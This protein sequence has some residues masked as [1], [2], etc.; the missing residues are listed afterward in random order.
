MCQ[1]GWIYDHFPRTFISRQITMNY[2]HEWPTC[3]KWKSLRATGTIQDKRDKLDKLPADMVIWKP[4]DD[5]RDSRPFDDVALFRGWL[6]HQ[7]DI[8]PLHP[9]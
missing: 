8:M 4:Y 6:H 1:Q 2:T 3:M 9:R 5:H 7:M